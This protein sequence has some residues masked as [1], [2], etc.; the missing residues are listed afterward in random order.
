MSARRMTS[1][2][3][4]P[5]TI[6][7]T[8]SPKIRCWPV[9]RSRF[10]S[11]MVW[12]RPARGAPATSPADRCLRHA[13]RRPGQWRPLCHGLCAQRIERCLYALRA[14]PQHRFRLDR[15]LLVDPG[16]AGRPTFDPTKHDQRGG[17]NLVNGW[18]YATF[19][20]FLKYDKPPYF[21]WVVACNLANLAQ[22]LYVPMTTAATLGGGAWGPGRRGGRSRRDAL[23]QHRQRPHPELPPWRQAEARRLFRG[24][25]ACRSDRRTRA[26]RTRP[27]SADLGQEP[28]RR[29][30]GFRRLEPDR[31]ALDRRQTVHRHHRQG[32]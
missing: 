32:R 14:R 25:R 20:D 18:I 24:R 1:S 2:S 27:L 17:L 8:P 11:R 4:R 21:G 12:A 16:A 13:G 6:A 15:A 31:P 10:G 5:P 30:S 7:S 23:R 22:Q 26:V 19:A 3:S 28:Q 9:R 29:R